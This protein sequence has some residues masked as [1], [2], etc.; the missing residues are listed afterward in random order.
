MR[1]LLGSLPPLA[2]TNGGTDP[3]D[4]NESRKTKRKLF[5]E[6]I[7]SSIE[8]ADTIKSCSEHQRRIVNDILTLSKMDSKLLQL[9]P[10]PVDAVA[11]LHDLFK[12]FAAETEHAGVK[13]EIQSDPSI[14]E[15]GVQWVVL[16]PGRVLQVLVNLVTN[17]IKFTKSRNA[18]RRVT[19]CIGSAKERPIH[20]PV[21]FVV[22]RTIRDSMYNSEEFS[23]DPCYLWFSVQ[24]TG[25]GMTAEE[26]ARI[27][28]R[29]SQ[30]SRRTYNQYG[31]SGLGLF[32][33]RELVEMQG[34]EIGVASQPNIGS[35]F[36]FFIKTHKTAAPAQEAA[37]KPTS[38]GH[39]AAEA[40][41][42]DK[43]PSEISVLVVEDNAVNQ[44]VLK[45]QLQKHGYRVH[46]ADHGLE[47]LDFI[48]TTR[49]WK[50]ASTTTP[51]DLDVILMDVEMPKMDGLTCTKRIREFEREGS[52]TSHIP[53]IAVSA[54]ARPEQIN[55]TIIAGMD[56]AI[57]KPFRIPDLTPRID[58]LA[59]SAR[60]KE[61]AERGDVGVRTVVMR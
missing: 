28:S 45:K 19:V 18:I 2:S 1:K 24:D 41:D 23:E 6:Q 60:S 44:R 9:A 54:N 36:A 37:A 27:F 14:A 15:L 20:L 39:K 40:T 32:I 16:D 25:C 3:L 17:A 5:H 31:G 56:E 21:D 46:V 50:D 61:M 43:V 11:L 51:Q 12:M 7:E 8:A 49:H 57:S 26:Q 38:N 4:S 34:G 33:S 10:S 58:R 53:I 59:N 42:Q 52:I 35:T 48:R 13:I 29:F 55:Q 47:A 22:A 30:A